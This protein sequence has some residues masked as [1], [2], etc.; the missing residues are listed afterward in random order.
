MLPKNVFLYILYRFVIKVK[1][2]SVIAITNKF[3]FDFVK[4]SPSFQYFTISIVRELFYRNHLYRYYLEND[5]QVLLLP[6][7]WNNK[8]TRS[9]K[10]DDTEPQKL[11]D[12]KIIDLRTCVHQKAPSPPSLDVDRKGEN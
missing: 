1:V 2:F 6:K 5:N 7:R 3:Y 8:R 9:G 10:Q 12:E 11:F 4:I